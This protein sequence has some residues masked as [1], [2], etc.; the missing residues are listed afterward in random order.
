MVGDEVKLPCRTNDSF[1][2]DWYHMPSENERSEIVEAGHIVSNNS[3]RFAIDSSVQGDFNLIIISATSE[4]EGTYMC[5]EH[6]G[7]GQEHRMTLN[8]LSK[9][10]IANSIQSTCNTCCRSS[11][12]EFGIVYP[13]H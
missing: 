3:N 10:S 2:V 7:L 6:A 9:I 4:D 1:P 5:V 12:V 13:K 8:V 11:T